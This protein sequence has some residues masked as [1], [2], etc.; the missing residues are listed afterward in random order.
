MPIRPT[1]PLILKCSGAA[2]KTGSRGSVAGVKA[3]LRPLLR[4]G[5]SAP[6]GDLS[7]LRASLRD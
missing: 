1:R 5:A 4:S 7:G 3:H 2:P 6:K